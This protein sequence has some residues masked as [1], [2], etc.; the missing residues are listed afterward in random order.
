MLEVF[1]GKKTYV[2]AGLTI[3]A[4]VITMFAPDVATAMHIVVSDPGS[5]VA[6]AFM[7]IFL[8]KGIAG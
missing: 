7:I 8:R 5:L 3:L 6:E 2:A 4:A 1:K